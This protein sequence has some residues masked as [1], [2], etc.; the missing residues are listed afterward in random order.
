M[1]REPGAP[2]SV[3]TGMRRLRKWAGFH[4]RADLLAAHAG[5]FPRHPFLPLLGRA[6]NRYNFRNQERGDTHLKYWTLQALQEVTGISVGVQLVST[7]ILALMEAGRSAD[8]S[9]YAA[10]LRALADAIDALLAEKA[11]ATTNDD[12]RLLLEHLYDTWAAKGVDCRTPPG[13]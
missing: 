5:I 7:H 11:P 12:Q 9:Q 13:E 1:P 2:P 6:L 4:H 3:L 10:G 8:A